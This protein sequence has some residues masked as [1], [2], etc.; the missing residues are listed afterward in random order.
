MGFQNLIT[1]LADVVS[2]VANNQ[3]LRSRDA[4]NSRSIVWI[5]EDDY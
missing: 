1:M 5:T 3:R 2:S 4:C